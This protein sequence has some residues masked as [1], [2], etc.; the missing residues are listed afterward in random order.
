MEQLTIKSSQIAI[1]PQKMNLVAGL[2]R[3]KELDFSLNFLAFLP[4]KGG[5]I[6]HKLLQGA[7]KTLINSKEETSN[8]YLNKIE[9]NR[10]RIQKK[11][12]YRAKGR[13]DRVRRRYCLINLFLAKKENIK[14]DNNGTES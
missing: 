3:R 8:F 2:I 5:R 4:K 13:T 12:M 7:A 6:L 1:S 9:V 14:I 11:V 10:G